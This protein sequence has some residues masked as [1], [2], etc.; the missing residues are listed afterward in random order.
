LARDGLGGDG[1]RLAFGGIIN[2]ADSKAGLH[3]SGP[4]E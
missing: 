3:K 1:I 2:G 4:K